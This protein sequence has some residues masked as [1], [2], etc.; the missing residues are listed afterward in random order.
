MNLNIKLGQFLFFLGSQKYKSIGL[1]LLQHSIN[2]SVY[3]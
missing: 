2:W 3:N 1:Q